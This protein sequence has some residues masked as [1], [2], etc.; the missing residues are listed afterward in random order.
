MAGGR[1]LISA[2]RPLPSADFAM[3]RQAIGSQVITQTKS[4]RV[5][6]YPLCHPAPAL[7][8]DLALIPILE[9]KIRSKIMSRSR[10][11]NRSPPTHCESGISA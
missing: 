8:P 2:L 4:V 1:V 9:T 10:K 11:G 3:Q 7:D 6:S 5:F